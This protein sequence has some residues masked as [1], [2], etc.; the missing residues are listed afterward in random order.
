MRTEFL[1]DL[2][3]TGSEARVYLALL[4]LGQSTAGPIVDEAKVTRSK[5]YDIL[6]RLK[7]KGLVSFITKQQTKYFSAADPQNILSYIEQK[8][9]AVLDQKQKAKELLPKLILEQQIAKHQKTGEIFIGYKGMKSAFQT[10]INEF[11]AN[12]TYYAFGASTGSNEKKIEQFFT[13]LQ[14]ERD[15]KNVHMNIIFTKEAKGKFPYQEQSKRVTTKYYLT[16]AATG[17]NIYKDRTIITILTEEPITI[18]INNKEAADSFRK[19]FEAI[20][21]VAKA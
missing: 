15:K 20:W 21:K 4:H 12:E 1:E 14:K 19:Y 6:E 13:W 3:L 10:M 2:G 18:L 11:D 17:I 7:Q 5:I 16:N 8:E 9:Q